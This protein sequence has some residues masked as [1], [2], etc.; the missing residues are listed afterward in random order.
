LAAALSVSPRTLRS[1]ARR[2]PGDVARKI[3]RCWWLNPAQRRDWQIALSRAESANRKPAHLNPSNWTENGVNRDAAIR[4]LIAQADKSAAF[5]HGKGLSLTDADR[6]FAAEHGIGERTLRK[7]RKIIAAGGSF[8]ETRGRKPGAQ[9]PGNATAALFLSFYKRPGVKLRSA[10]RM[11]SA[12]AARHPNAPAWYWPSEATIRRWRK[13][14]HPA[15]YLDRYRKGSDAWRAEHEPKLDRAPLDLP[16]N[17]VWEIDA[18]KCNFFTEHN[19]RKVRP[20]Y[21]IA[22]DVGTRLFVGHAVALSEST[23]PYIRTLRRGA[24]AVGCPNV[25]RADQGK[26]LQGAGIGDL[27][28]R[29]SAVDWDQITGIVADMLSEFQPMTGRSGWMKGTVESAVN[30]I[31]MGFDPL[32]ESY[33]GNRPA[34]RP[35]GVDRWAEDHLDELP[36]LADVDRQLG[37]FLEA[38]N[39]RPRADLGRLSPLQKFNATAIEFRKVPD[40]VL[41]FRLLRAQRVRVS[42]QG[43]PIRSGGGVVYFA[44]S[45][46]RVWELQGQEVIARID[47]DDLS[48]VLLCDKTGRPLFYVA[49]DHVRGVTSQTLREVGKRKQKARKAVREHWEQID[50]A[51]RP[52]VDEAIR[53]QRE[54]ADREAARGRQVAACDRGVTILHS[55]FEDALKRARRAELR[56]TGTDETV[57]APDESLADV[58]NVPGDGMDAVPEL[59]FD[60]VGDPVMEDHDDD[61]MQYLV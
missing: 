55:Q 44:Q 9:P 28:R 53:L 43:V 48:E 20:V 24:L 39:R 14:E 18:S 58:V 32:F 38:E 54:C 45:D 11:V 12:A 31:G 8:P 17:A 16:G 50:V 1:E 41:S 27:S 60:D 26:A 2:L 36:T 15:F 40:A 34:N 46:R 42:N 22:V 7:W 4:K 25:I 57:P 33:C 6:V 47:D 52:T 35:R 10:W 59:T 56:A 37:E 30:V 49:N 51:A 19:G 23:E 5:L 13:R 21:T 61:P 3:S 29:K